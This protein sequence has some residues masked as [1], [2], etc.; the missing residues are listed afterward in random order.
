MTLMP[1]LAASAAWVTMRSGVRCAETT[2]ISRHFQFLQYFARLFHDR[3]VACGTHD[4]AYYR[5]CH[6]RVGL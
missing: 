6:G 3:K 1:R 4:D 2:V 5:L